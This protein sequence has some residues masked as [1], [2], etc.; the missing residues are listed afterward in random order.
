M[1]FRPLETDDIV[2]RTLLYVIIIVSVAMILLPFLYALS[3]SFRT[4]AEFFVDPHWIPRDPTLEPW[5]RGFSELSRQ[6]KNSALIATG[7]AILALIITIPGAYVFGRT[8]FPGKNFAFYAIV[9]ALMFPYILLI[10]PIVDLWN[11]LGIYNTIPGLWIAYQVFVTPF[12]IWILRDYFEKLPRNLEEAAQV[13]GCTQFTAFVRVI[14]PLSA[15]AIVAVGFIAFLVGWNDF[16]FSNLLTTGSGPRP[17]VVTL[18][19]TTTGGERNYWAL[20][21]AQ[22]LIIGTPP[23]ILYMAARRYLENAFAV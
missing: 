19:V 5:I 17:A 18:F 1:N 4:R 21:M 13:Y 8:D 9:I 20:V 12:A 11:D 6:L 10:I 16:L 7:T 15:P 14:L 22:T 23:T 2:Y 3:V